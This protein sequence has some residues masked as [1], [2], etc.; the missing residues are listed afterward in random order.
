MPGRIAGALSPGAS[1]PSD[2][3]GTRVESGS[4]TS[5]ADTV[6]MACAGWSGDVKATVAV[7]LSRTVM[8]RIRGGVVSRGNVQRR[9]VSA[10]AATRT[11]S[12]ASPGSRAWSRSWSI[13]PNTSY[14][15]DGTGP[16]A[17]R[18]PATASTREGGRL[19]HGAHAV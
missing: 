2:T 14:V 8:S 4:R 3:T 1:G 10:P 9:I 5:T 19:Y 15:A 7:T 6:S 18:P 16:S 13:T 17:K 12:N 11:E